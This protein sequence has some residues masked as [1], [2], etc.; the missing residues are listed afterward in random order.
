MFSTFHS[1]L[2]GEAPAPAHCFASVTVAT[3]A[4]DKTA[5]LFC[6]ST[7]RHVAKNVL[8]VRFVRGSAFD[9]RKRLA[10][11]RRSTSA[12]RGSV[13]PHVS[14]ERLTS[15]TPVTAAPKSRVRLDSAAL[16]AIKR[17]FSCTTRTEC[18]TAPFI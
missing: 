2:D 11:F 12:R 4:G 18:C 14:V 7:T 9:Q 13:F 10:S 1:A 3:V 17:A 15:P 6:R 8:R 16:R 5:R